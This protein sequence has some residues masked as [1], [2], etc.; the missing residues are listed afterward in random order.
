[1]AEGIGGAGPVRQPHAPH[2]LDTQ[3]LCFIWSLSARVNAPASPGRGSTHLWG[4]SLFERPGDPASSWEAPIEPQGDHPIQAASGPDEDTTEQ[5][6]RHEL[7]QRS[8]WPWLP[9]QTCGHLAPHAYCR[10]CG[11]VK[12][13]GTAAPLKMGGIVNLIAKLSKR[14]HYDGVKITEAQRRLIVK[15][16]ERREAD[17]A[18][19]LTREV[20]LEVLAEVIGRYTGL[21][22]DVVIEYLRSC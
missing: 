16:L 22:A 2:E 4:A 5:G 21:H 17:D 9:T 20:Q 15:E 8:D 13:V 19:A 7:A 1:M 3:I 6:P 18:F 14:L 11:A 12:A 10:E